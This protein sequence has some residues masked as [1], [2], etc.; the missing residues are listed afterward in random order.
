[1]SSASSSSSDTYRESGTLPSEESGGRRPKGDVRPHWHVGD[2]LLDRY[3]VTEVLG[4]PGQSGMG[5]V[6]VVLDRKER[7]VYAAKTL[8]EWRLR[9][10]RAVRAFEREARLW[11]DL[12]KHPNIVQAHFIEKVDGRP[13][14][15]LEHV[16]GGDLSHRLEAGPLGVRRALRY[17]IHFSRG[18]VHARANIPG[19]VHRDVKPGNCLI[20]AEDVA[21]VTD[22]GLAVVTLEDED[23]D[24]EG[25]GD[26]S[27]EMSGLN[28][29]AGTLAYMPPEA[30]QRPP[31]LDSRSDIYSFGVMLY[32]MLTGRYPLEADSYMGWMS[33]HAAII[34]PSPHSR[35]AGIPG[36]LGD[37]VMRCLEKKT[38][39]RPAGFSSIR[40]ELEATLVGEFG[41]E[42][43]K[44]APERIE[45]EDLRRRGV[46]LHRLGEDAEALETLEM[47]LV[48]D[49]DS[50]AA[51]SDRAEVHAQAGRQEE[52]FSDLSR[53]LEID[54]RRI[55][56][57]LIKCRLFER[58]G[59]LEEALECCEAALSQDGRSVETWLAR[60]RILEARHDHVHAL[61]C[62]DRVSRMVPDDARGWLGK[63]RVLVSLGSVD[64][65][66]RLLGRALEL[67]RDHA[68]AWRVRAAG[69]AR[70]GHVTRALRSVDKA[71]AREPDDTASWKTKGEILLGE[72]RI[73]EAVKALDRALG[74]SPGDAGL[75]STLGIAHLAQGRVSDAIVDFEGAMARDP[76]E[77]VYMANRARALF[78]LGRVDD[79]R[80]GFDEALEKDPDVIVYIRGFEEYEKLGL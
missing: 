19:F 9:K 41:E 37:L 59:R 49:P 7:V 51:L 66:L 77:A 17:A 14:L 72:G 45:A 56:T 32:R 28:K 31:E 8:Q 6:L 27:I 18:M 36:A 55:D 43:E 44:P 65:A 64:E 52:A 12:G 50:A 26:R 54:P 1:M 58:Q 4:G 67:D 24:E 74:L 62:Y 35:N 63:G 3:E 16:E 29:V 30:F 79:A 61:H 47:A 15:F 13:F 71:L 39:G 60:G 23:E 21:K 22:F 40:Q 73:D 70:Q 57:L 68:E 42:L 10:P 80:R 2:V 46:S 25:D 34:P 78:L 5:I 11:M 33:K 38:E 20:T 53:A 69:L 76:D 75:W 48:L